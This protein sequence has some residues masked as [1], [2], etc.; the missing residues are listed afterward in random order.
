[1]NYNKK[2]KEILKRYQMLKT[3]QNIKSNKSKPMSSLAEQD[4]EMEA[5]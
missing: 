2:L 4:F 3:T 1:M 5:P